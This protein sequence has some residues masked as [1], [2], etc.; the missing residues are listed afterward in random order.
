MSGREILLNRRPLRAPAPLAD[1]PDR[2][3]AL[4]LIASGAALALASCE[5]PRRE[6]IPYV[7]ER[8]ELGAGQIRRYATTLALAGYGAGVI[9]RVID[10]RPVKLEGNPVHPGSLGSTDVF[11]EAAILDLYDPARSKG[12]Y[13]PTGPTSW[14]AAA[15]ALQQRLRLHQADRGAGFILATGRITGPTRLALIGSLRTQFPA[16]QWIRYEPCHDDNASGGARL[17]F[18]APLSLQPRFAEA[19]VILSLG[20][21]PLGPGPGQVPWSRA[22]MSRRVPSRAPGPMSRIYVAESG[23]TPTGASADHRLAADPGLLR[24]MAVFVASSFGAGAAAPSLPSR[25]A[26]FLKAAVADLFAAKGKA[27]VLTGENESREMHAL[28][29]WINHALDAPFDAIAPVD[30]HPD[31][32]GLSL[33]ALIEAANSGVVRT[34]VVIGA[35]PAYDGPDPAAMA[36]AIRRTPFSF[37][38]GEYVDETAHA[39]TW[40]APMSHGLE[41]WSDLRAIDG[42]ASVVQPLIAPLYDS[43]P[44]EVLLSMMGGGAESDPYDLLKDSWSG[45]AG[46]DPESWMRSALSAGIV[47]GSAATLQAPPTPSLIIPPAIA[48]RTLVL[49]LKPNASL[50]DGSR[51]PN[52]WLQECPEPLTKEVWG[53]SLRLGAD[54]AARMGL[55]DGDRIRVGSGVGSLDAT[56]RIVQGQARGVI[57]MPLGG[58][59]T[60]AGPI[61]NGIGNNPSALRGGDLAWR[62]Q[63]VQLERLGGGS[64]GLVTQAALKLDGETDRLLPTLT[65]AALARGERP[66]DAEAKPPTEL[67]P[68]LAADHAWAL[69]V[70]LQACIGCNACVVAC[71]AENNVPA[72]GPAEIADGRDMHWLRIDRYDPGSD[73]DPKTG[74]EPVPCMQCEHAPCEPVCPVEASVHDREGLNDQVYN[75]CVGT[76]FCQTN[77]PYKVRRFNFRKYSAPTLWKG[78]DQGTIEAQHNPDVTVRDR[79]VMEKCTYCVQRIAA[80]KAE[81]I[82]TGAPIVDGD[83]VPACQAAC[84]TKAITFGDLFNPRARILELRAEPRHFSLLGHLGTRPRTTYLARLRNPDPALVSEERNA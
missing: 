11:T 27:I 24:D 69:S 67:P 82:R 13:G 25:P 76:R 29:A 23:L 77:C 9:G 78:L 72:V 56:A 80:A 16:M 46:A 70:D 48:A 53:S 71:Q 61:G 34:L 14:S 45:E 42:T 84:P 39:S 21:D 10:G 36:E 64:P 19:D 51:A 41:S 7:T 35:N 26:A 63:G 40:H 68:P 49:D 66:A 59:R 5:P 20:A 75:R 33:A 54:D 79:G 32:H 57:V 81:A 60:Q 17:A 43:R 12:A 44:A 37:H 55:K 62:R 6:I 52:A 4:A 50:W 15:G 30:P 2:R 3:Q 8:D 47:P 74:F 22:I 73:E 31:L 83:I 28:V 58:G 18:G 65:L 1:S 38:L